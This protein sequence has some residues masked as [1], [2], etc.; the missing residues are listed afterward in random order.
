ML[1]P[2]RQ[3]PG[4]C[5]RDTGHSLRMAQ[6]M[7]MMKA[8]SQHI[9]EVRSQVG[10]LQQDHDQFPFM[11]VPY[12]DDEEDDEQDA[13]AA[14]ICERCAPRSASS[15]RI[16]ITVRPVVPWDDDDE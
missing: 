14:V 13:T 10:K 2:T 1:P 12:D 9:Q 16:L 15:S 8:M 11:P 4:P 6:T 5:S 7:E 3:S